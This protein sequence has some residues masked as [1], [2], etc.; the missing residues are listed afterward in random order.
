MFSRKAGNLRVC[1]LPK[2]KS[3]STLEVFLNILLEMEPAGV[4]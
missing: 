1:V 2:K 4:F 3:Q